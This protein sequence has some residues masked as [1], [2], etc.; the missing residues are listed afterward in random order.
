MFNV[1]RGEGKVSVVSM[2]HEFQLDY[3]C[4]HVP[5][6]LA[7]RSLKMFNVDRGEGE[8]SAVSVVH[9]F[10]WI[11]LEMMCLFCLQLKA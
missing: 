6:L 1:D 9:K 3:T 11:V 8:V 5:V 10:Q 4:D 7:A 2:V